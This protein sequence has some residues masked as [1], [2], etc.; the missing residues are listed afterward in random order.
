MGIIA[1]MANMPTINDGRRAATLR[2]HRDAR[3]MSQ[4]QVGELVGLGKT[5]VSRIETGRRAMTPRNRTLLERAFRD[6]PVLHT[7]G[8]L[9]VEAA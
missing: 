6:L 9:D 4:G 8:D 3:G 5:A 7:D 1:T 2:A